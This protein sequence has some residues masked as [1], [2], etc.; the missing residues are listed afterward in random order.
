MRLV[1]IAGA[2]GDLVIIAVFWVIPLDLG[3]VLYIVTLALAISAVY[4]LWL[5]HMFLPKRW[6]RAAE[7]SPKT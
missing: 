7:G 1:G 5:T 2:I 3:Q 6:D 4:L